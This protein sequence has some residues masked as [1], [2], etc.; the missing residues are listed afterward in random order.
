MTIGGSVE[1]GQKLGELQ[2]FVDGQLRDTIALTA[3]R[4]V[5]RL[6]LGG[7]FRDLLE[8]LFMAG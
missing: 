3:V 4:P 7:I 2:V 6:S 8:K 1:P 5:E